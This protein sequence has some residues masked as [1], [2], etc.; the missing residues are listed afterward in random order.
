MEK[1]KTVRCGYCDAKISEIAQYCPHCRHNNKEAYERVTIIPSLGYRKAKSVEGYCK[2][3]PYTG[4]L[5][6]TNPKCR[7]IVERGSM[8]CPFCGQ[9]FAD[10]QAEDIKNDRKQQRIEFRK[11]KKLEKTKASL[12]ACIVAGVLTFFT[13]YVAMDNA[14]ISSRLWEMN[15]SSVFQYVLR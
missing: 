14:E 11:K 7:R 5:Y 9:R 3:A 15:E 10:Y 8:F 6:C 13:L 4:R 12:V 2:H 1:E